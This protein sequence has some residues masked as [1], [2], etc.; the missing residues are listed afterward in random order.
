MLVGKLAM[1]QGHSPRKVLK[2][3]HCSEGLE[4]TGTLKLLT[5]SKN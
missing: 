1:F 4:L 5:Q 2:T 3:L